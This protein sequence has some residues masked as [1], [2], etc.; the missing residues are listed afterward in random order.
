[1][2][3]PNFIID[4]HLSL[5]GL[6]RMPP[7]YGPPDDGAQ[8][9]TAAQASASAD[10]AAK[11][12]GEAGTAPRGQWRH[13]VTALSIGTACTLAAALL[14]W[15]TGQH[16]QPA[17][18]FD[19]PPVAVIAQPTALPVPRDDV[20]AAPAASVET[21]EAAESAES[22]KSAAMTAAATAVARAPDMAFDETE[23]PAPVIAA[24]SPAMTR[25]PV[26]PMRPR[27]LVRAVEPARTPPELERAP[28][29]HDDA[30]ADIETKL[31]TAYIAPIASDYAAPGT[32]VR[33]ELQRHAR[34]TD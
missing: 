10:P 3:S 12:C 7:P 28:T 20:P 33:I 34:L 13:P 11:T 27:A 4:G 24:A 30:S 15:Q 14:G 9:S 23:V 5:P 22:A 8:R 21:H 25:L 29:L 2:E 19:Q 17:V 1:M 16:R 31:A 32:P 6:V 18:E 26:K